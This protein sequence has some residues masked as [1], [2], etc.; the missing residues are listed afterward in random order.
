MFYIHETE[1]IRQERPSIIMI[2]KFDGFHRGH[3]KI[4]R[5]AVADR[6]GDRQV[7]VFTFSRSPQAVLT[8]RGGTSLNTRREKL[9][10]AERF[11]AD[12]MIE[13]PFTEEVR[14]MSAE[15]FLHEI[16]LE[17]LRVCEIVAGPDCR[18]GYERQGDMAF[19]KEK[20]REL[21]FALRI[22]EKERYEGEVISSSRIRA[23][24]LRGD[25][26]EADTMLGYSFG[27]E[28]EIVH[29]RRLGRKLGFPTINQEIP[30]GKLVPAMGVYAAE[31]FL[32][33]QRFRGIANVGV[34]PTVSDGEEKAGHRIAG[35]ET[36]IFDFHQDVYGKRARVELKHFIRP[37]KHFA[38][39]ESLKGQVERD[40]KIVREY[41]KRA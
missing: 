30:L 32:E 6:T 1:K 39:L 20:S 40:T 15:T 34:K 9:A 2:G 31:I 4:L 37:E 3:Q 8:G 12:G 35:I 19:L 25:V 27:Y 41:W 10:L 16:L 5:E 26:E 17:Q 38:T 18:F 22:V 11:G 33:G 24:L 28:A 36:S 13:Y 7:V 21:G 29:G 23:A 14:R